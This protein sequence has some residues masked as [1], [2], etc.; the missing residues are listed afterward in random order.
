MREFDV[1]PGRVTESVFLV[2]R[3]VGLHLRK[4]KQFLW[5]RLG[6][7][8]RIGSSLVDLRGRKTG[9]GVMAIHLPIVGPIANRHL[10]DCLFDDV[11]ASSPGN[12]DSQELFIIKYSHAANWP[13][14]KLLRH[15]M[16]GFR[17]PRPTWV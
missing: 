6:A 1:F 9:P 8:G 12:S 13:G 3:E 10:T 11:H 15:T 7:D 17:S 5:N 14:H 2:T 4:F 16:D